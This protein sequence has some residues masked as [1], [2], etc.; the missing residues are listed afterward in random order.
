MA[1]TAPTFNAIGTS[2]TVMMVA[3]HHIINNYHTCT[4]AENNLQKK[5]E[6]HKWM[7]APDTSPSYNAARKK[8]QPGTGSWFLDG[9]KFSQWKERAGSVLWLRGGPGCG[10]TIL[11]SS[12]IKNVMEFCQLKPASRG[13][14]YFFFDGTKAQSESL[15]YE[16]LT[17]SLITQ[18]SDRCGDN[19]PDALVDMY[20]KCDSGHRQPL[21]S[22]LEG[23]LSKIMETFDST[24][25]VIDSL[26]ECVEKTDLLKWIQ[27][28]AL[29]SS[30]KLHLMLAS[31]PEAQIE[32]SLTS[33]Y[34][35]QKV[36]VGDR[37]TVDDIN[38]YLDARLQAPDMSQWNECEKRM[39][40]TALS[41][42]SNGMFRW[43]YLQLDAVN[44]C[45]N[46][47][48]LKK[49][50]NTLPRGLDETY[51]QI[52]ERSECPDYLQ[53]LL[54]WLVFSKRPLAMAELAE[55]LAF[56]FTGDVPIYDPDM[57]C[58]TSAVIWRI[59]NG[60]VTE[61][62]GT[63][64]L[65]HF[66]V[67][68]Y[69]IARIESE[70]QAQHRTS[71]QFSHC[72]IT[73]GCLAQLVHFDGPSVLDWERPR[74]IVLDHIRSS[75]PLA[76]YAAMNWVSHFHSCGTAATQCPR[77]SKLLL[78]LF[79][80]PSMTWSHALLSWVRLQNLAI[81]TD[82]ISSYD[83]TVMG[84]SLKSFCTS[85]HLP[86]D[87][88][89]LYYAC[90]SGSFLAVQHLVSNGADV[91][92]AGREA[93]TR[94]LLVA[95]QES[96]VEI[97]RLLLVKGANVDV[98]GGNYGTALQTASRQGHLT[99]AKLLLDK[100]SNPNIEG[101]RDGPALQVAIVAG[102]LEL[103]KLLL[104]HGAA[105][106]IV[107]G[108]HG[109]ALIAASRRGQLE[110]VEMLLDKG[111]NA[112]IIGGTC[113]TALQ[114]AIGA[115]HLEL[116]ELLL[117][118]GADCN[119]EGGD[120]GSALH[121]AITKGY[122]ELAKL[123]LEK[124]ANA[125]TKGGNCGTALQAAITAG[126]LELATLLLDKG[127]D[128]NVQGGYYGTALQAASRH[129]HLE[130][131]KLLLHKGAR[132]NAAGGHYGTALQVAIAK[133]HLNLATLLLD[134]GADVNIRGGLYGTALQAAAAGGQLEFAKLLLDKGANVNDEGGC[135]GTA[136]QAA[137]A[138]GHFELAKLLLKRGVV[139]RRCWET[140]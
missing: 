114:A 24:Y 33:L 67:K 122:F 8:H 105:V 28:V 109:T 96:H 39:I 110:L 6:I 102:H 134:N 71:E 116:A 64:K 20:H 76:R 29:G 72:V 93:S 79:K 74:P 35:L 25:I 42:G 57:R 126:H 4:T 88:S 101:G 127:A 68:E 128:C 137:C 56:D 49:Q 87:V 89:P 104:E 11:S 1:P 90:F 45:K 124:G 51:A 47:K 95:S 61:F 53:Q 13:Y 82:A 31:R 17:R 133:D 26:D 14:A 117:D 52:F 119:V 135:H 27:S 38:A 60:L 23:T 62:E 112:N 108:S 40:K 94:P 7:K 131:V 107:G 15:N 2:G 84:R 120:Y 30:G 83:S 5:R 130:F 9:S 63:A 97:V 44:K 132:V 48:E 58:N 70:A 69:L 65:A 46:K 12:V 121:V 73:Q 115:G 59:C 100:G 118:R 103:A 50:L 106:N 98:K 10:K 32:Q 99:L 54:Q 66:S 139:R 37:S 78:Q 55:V 111:A 18:L 125:N 81:D 75:F 91:D 22:Q 140:R 85:R 21:E 19:I 36:S 138:S 136:L 3:G 92:K 34:N 86:L 77:L 43:V 113:G 129:G 16:S 41:A 123:L 80:L